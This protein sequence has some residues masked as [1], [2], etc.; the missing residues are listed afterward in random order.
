MNVARNVTVV[1]NRKPLVV[2]PCVGVEA[3]GPVAIGAGLLHAA[4]VAAGRRPVAAAN[5]ALAAHA[6]PASLLN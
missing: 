6:T 3:P 1:S 4:R 2:H 5:D